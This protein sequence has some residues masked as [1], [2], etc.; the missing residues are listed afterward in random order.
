MDVVK[1]LQEHNIKPSVQRM[2]IMDYLIKHRTH[3]TVDE[4]YTALS[5]SIP[6]LSK[7]TVYNTLKLLSEQGAAQT[8]TIDERNTCYDADTTPHAHFLCK[9]CGKIYDLKCNKSMK[10]VVDMD[11]D[12]H[13]IQEVHYYYKGIC[14]HCIE[15]KNA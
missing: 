5:P 12:G 6:T 15:Q 8:L 10:Q 9:Q 3:P 1:R 7:T 14:K 4:I 13:D 11:L 2:A